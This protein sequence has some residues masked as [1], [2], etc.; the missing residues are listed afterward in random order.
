MKTSLV[1]FF[2]SGRGITTHFKGKGSWK[3]G[4]YHS[5]LERRLERG[6]NLFK[7]IQ[8]SRQQKAL[9][10]WSRS[11]CLLQ[12]LNFSAQFKPPLHSHGPSRGRCHVYARSPAGD[13]ELLQDRAGSHRPWVPGGPRRPPSSVELCRKDSCAEG[14]A[15]GTLP[16]IRLPSPA[17]ARPDRGKVGQVLA[18]GPGGAWTHR[19]GAGPQKEGRHGRGYPAH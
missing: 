11:C 3:E 12:G 6:R 15:A 18:A 17:T 2:T 5:H 13:R 9:Q 8:W 10:V 14:T 19:P 7:V 1:E 16:G 4:C